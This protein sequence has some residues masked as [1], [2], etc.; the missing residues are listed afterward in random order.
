MAAFP[1]H[2]EPLPYVVMLFVSILAHQHVPDSDR[3]AAP[4]PEASVA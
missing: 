4:D 2:G 3:T 1:V